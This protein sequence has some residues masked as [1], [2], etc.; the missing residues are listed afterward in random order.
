MKTRLRRNLQLQIQAQW[1]VILL[2]LILQ[3]SFQQSS[4]KYKTVMISELFRHGARTAYNDNKHPYIKTVGMGNLTGNGER[5]HFILGQ[6]VRDNYKGLFNYTKENP[7]TNM[8]YQLYSSAVPRCIISGNS[9]L[10]GLFPPGEAIG[11]VVTSDNDLT[12]TPEYFGEFTVSF[13]NTS[14][15]PYGIRTFPI[16]TNNMEIDF[17][18][19]NFVFKSCPDLREESMMA[20]Q[21]FNGESKHLLNITDAW[22]KRI[23]YDPR[24]FGSDVW[25][26][27]QTYT[28][29]DI[30]RY[31]I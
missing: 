30:V 6:Q 1:G 19:M 24:D 10:L 18:F 20:R 5:M 16:E 14:S 4:P 28:I 15:L 3:G 23:G 2:A 8:D 17:L 22:M 7:I 27:I 9:H 12:R 21:V 25:D 26:M 29:F 31:K 11:D 13:H